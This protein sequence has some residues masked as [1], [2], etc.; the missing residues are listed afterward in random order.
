MPGQTW[1]EAALLFVAMWLAM[2]IAMMLPSAFPTWL[3][4]RRTR[5]GLSA[6]A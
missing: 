3:L 1:L 5:S 4:C 2:M 6:T